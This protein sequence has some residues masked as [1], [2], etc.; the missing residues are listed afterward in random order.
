MKRE[1]VTSVTLRLCSA[2]DERELRRLAE[3]DST[4]PLTGTVLVA[5]QAGELRAALALGSRLVV[6]DPFHPTTD[7][8]ELLRLRAAQL[9]PEDETPATRV[10]ARLGSVGAGAPGNLRSIW[11]RAAASETG[12]RSPA[13]RHRLAYDP[14]ARTSTPAGQVSPFVRSSTAPRPG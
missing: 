1:Q 9:A 4:A 6:A 10:R 12:V 7:L 3:L 11:S 14:P 13:R 2:D 8:V 5:Q